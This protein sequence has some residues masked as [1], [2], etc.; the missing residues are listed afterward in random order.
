MGA[1]ENVLAHNKKL[2]PPA[3]RAGAQTRGAASPSCPICL[4]PL[5]ES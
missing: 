4:R 5:L 3:A 2:S 1:V